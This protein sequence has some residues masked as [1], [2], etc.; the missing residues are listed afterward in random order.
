M[1]RITCALLACLFVVGCS[2]QPF[3]EDEAYEKTLRSLPLKLDPTTSYEDRVRILDLLEDVHPLPDGFH[4]SR[5]GIRAQTVWQMES[6]RA[7]PE[8]SGR[9]DGW[10]GNIN[11]TLGVWQMRVLQR[12]RGEFANIEMTVFDDFEPNEEVSRELLDLYDLIDETYAD[13]EEGAFGRHLRQHELQRENWEFHVAAIESGLAQHE[14]GLEALPDGEREF[15]AAW[16]Y[17]MVELLSIMNFPTHEAWIDPFIDA[18]MPDFI[19]Q[20]ED[21]KF[22]GSSGLPFEQHM[23]CAG[24]YAIHKFEQW[25]FHLIRKTLNL[26]V[27]SID[28]AEAAVHIFAEAL[29]DDDPIDF[30]WWALRNHT[31]DHNSLP[32]TAPPPA[33]EEEDHPAQQTQQT[34][35]TDDGCGDLTYKGACN[36]GSVEWCEEGPQQLDCEGNGLV[37]GWNAGKGYFD[38]IVNECGD[39]D[40]HGVCQDGVLSWCEDD[41]PMSLDC[42]AMSLTCGVGSTFSHHVCL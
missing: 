35:Q 13:P 41:S 21:L 15:A 14:A 9:I 38:C 18:T 22:T 30:L 5:D 42:E 23:A 24:I 27:T 37:C 3:G 29:V 16:G 39:L 19:V 26:F 40:H 31:D 1:V 11:W 32:S 2:D 33:E 17:T 12:E 7:L 10:W 4:D 25:T 36:G 8:A 6:G 28:K 20:P 34:Q